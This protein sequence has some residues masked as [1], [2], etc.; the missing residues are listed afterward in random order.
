MAQPPLPQ[1]NT[2]NVSRAGNA[3]KLFGRNTMRPGAPNAGSD[4]VS[5]GPG[6]ASGAPSTGNADAIISGVMPG[7]CAKDAP[8]THMAAA[9]KVQV[10]FL[11]IGLLSA[12]VARLAILFDAVIRQE[13][14]R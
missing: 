14:E 11:M 10:V 7:G 12:S 4:I 3:S 8:T 5:Y 6:T 2:G 13:V 1:A 9:A